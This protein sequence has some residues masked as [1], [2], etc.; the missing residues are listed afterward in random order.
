MNVGAT[1]ILD[2]AYFDD[3]D[4]QASNDDEENSMDSMDDPEDNV[5]LMELEDDL[6]NLMASTAQSGK[7][8]GVD[9]E[10]LP[11]FGGLAMKMPRKQLMSPP[12]LL[13]KEMIQFYQEIMPQMTGC[14]DTRGSRTSFS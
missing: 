8:R 13:F 12:K 1:S 14:K 11:R 2:Q 6:D 7:P 9:P 10:H 4:S 5:E 3:D